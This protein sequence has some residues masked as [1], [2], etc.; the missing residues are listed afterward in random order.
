MFTARCFYL[1]HW[2]EAMNQ[3]IGTKYSGTRYSEYKRCRYSVNRG[4]H[5][6]WKV[7]VEVVGRMESCPSYPGGMG[8]ERCPS[9][10]LGPRERRPS[11]DERER[12]R[13]V[14]S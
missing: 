4:L 3:R 14:T 13:T 10:T 5:E 8:M 12:R 11:L 1:T 9:S 7:E 6:G 2:K